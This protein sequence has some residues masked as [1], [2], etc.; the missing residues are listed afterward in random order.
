MPT[1]KAGNFHLNTQ[2]AQAADRMPAKPAPA[3]EP[4]PNEEKPGANATT[5]HDHGDGT[6]H[7]ESAGGE[8]TE[9]AHIGHALMHLHAKH[10]D[11]KAMHIHEH[12]SG[13][14]T[15]HVSDDGQVSGPEEHASPEDLQA[16]VGQIFAGEG[17]PAHAKP[18]GGAPSVSAHDVGLSGL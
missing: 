1:D 9:H 5:L 6:Y 16:H 15:H 10:A 7:T 8:R 11:G 4:K 12:G 18:E 14:M 2:R 17:E 3:A 13:H